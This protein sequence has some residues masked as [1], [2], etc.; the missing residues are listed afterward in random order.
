MTQSL[1]KSPTFNLTWSMYCAR[2]RWAL[3][4]K[5]T[6]S[7]ETMARLLFEKK[8]PK[9]MVLEV[10][11]TNSQQGALGFFELVRRDSY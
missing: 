11:L 10:V 6:S 9:H 2:C 1:A 8:I 4:P 3:G 5:A 7:L